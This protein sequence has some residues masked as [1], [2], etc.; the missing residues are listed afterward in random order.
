MLIQID[1]GIAVNPANIESI[2]KKGNNSRIIM[3]SGEKHVAEIPYETLMKICKD[4]GSMEETLRN[5]DRNTM[6][7][8]GV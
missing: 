8:R 4:K 3:T 1:T 2:E 6:R 5:I 7:Q